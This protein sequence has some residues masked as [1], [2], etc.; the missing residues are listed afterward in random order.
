V[1]EIILVIPFPWL[2]NSV[3]LTCINAL[4][5]YPE[6]LCLY[7]LGWDRLRAHYGILYI[8]VKGVTKNRF[9][10]MEGGYI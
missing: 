4:A 3:C 9:A 10:S 7:T 2:M 6:H 8:G 1:Y 5:Q